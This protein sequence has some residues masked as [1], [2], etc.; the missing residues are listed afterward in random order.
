[1]KAQII[2]CG[3][4]WDIKKFGIWQRLSNEDGENLIKHIGQWEAL[5]T[6]C[7]HCVKLY[8]TSAE[9]FERSIPMIGNAIPN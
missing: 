6:L 2:F 8:K 4:C 5:I 9:D 3:Q 7:P 1:M